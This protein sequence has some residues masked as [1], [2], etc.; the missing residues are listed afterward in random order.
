MERRLFCCF[1]CTAQAKK[2]AQDPHPDPEYALEKSNTLSS[3]IIV[4]ETTSHGDFT[5]S[6]IVCCLKA[7]DLQQQI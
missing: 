5:K 3:V 6:H 4:K 7:V 2:P 1:L